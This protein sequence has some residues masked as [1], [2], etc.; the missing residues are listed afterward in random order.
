MLV[1]CIK[2]FVQAVAGLLLAFVATVGIYIVYNNIKFN[3]VDITD[4]LV[5]DGRYDPAEHFVF[6]R[7]RFRR[8]R[9][10]HRRI[11]PH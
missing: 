2:L 9:I 7:W 1:R 10:S 11:Y 5:R 3:R 6:F 8:L 4:A